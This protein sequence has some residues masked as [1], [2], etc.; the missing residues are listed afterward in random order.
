[1][2]LHFKPYPNGFPDN[3]LRVSPDI[4]PKDSIYIEECWIDDEPYKDFHP[5][6]LT[7]KLPPGDQR[8]KVRV[9]ITPAT[10]L[11]RSK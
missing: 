6:E 1:M 9:K 10:W 8:R 5:T 7:V 2:Y 4:L 11:D 3:I